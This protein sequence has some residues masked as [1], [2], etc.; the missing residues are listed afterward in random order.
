[1]GEVA[2]EILFMQGTLMFVQTEV[3]EVHTIVYE[4]NEGAIQLATIS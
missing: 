3:E 4:H 1:M 2:K